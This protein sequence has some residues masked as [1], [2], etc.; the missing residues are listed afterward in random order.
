MLDVIATTDIKTVCV[1]MVAEVC[2]QCYFVS[3]YHLNMALTGEQ[4]V[5]EWSPH[6][7]SS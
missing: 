1:T 5:G 2:S 7:G 3:G 4:C 6:D